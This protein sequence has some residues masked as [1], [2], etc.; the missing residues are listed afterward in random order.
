M[1]L[2]TG[3]TGF[4]G[5]HVVEYLFQQ[6][7]I[8][9]G[10]FRKGSH[11]KVMDSA[12]VQGIEAD[13]LDHQS[14]H[15]AVEGADVVYSMA[16]PMPGV[17]S[18]FM[19]INTE[20]LR[21]LLRVAAESKVKAFVHLSTLEVYG[22]HSRLVDASAPFA[23]SNDYQRSKVESERL[24]REFSER[25]AEPRVVVLRAARALGSRDESLAV[26]LL[27]MASSG[28][29]VIPRGRAMSFS[30]PRDIA[31]AMLLA[32][33]ANLPTGRAF[34]LKSFDSTPEGVAAGVAEVVGSRAEIK[35]QGVFAPAGL[36]KYTSEQLRASARIAEQPDWK[37]LGYAPKYD[38]RSACEEIAAWFK[39]EPWVVEGA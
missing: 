29:M 10:I 35:R 7:E 39:K 24:L 8:S 3:A 17:D 36:P 15:E 27:R 37:E 22:F 26:P 21:N 19:R 25:N 2:L 11:L 12:G 38:L 4:I 20:G 5:S 33:T 28:R 23:P 18:D 30:H 34:L 16:S 31:Q 9:K 1:N 6:G 32:A 13:L 14:L